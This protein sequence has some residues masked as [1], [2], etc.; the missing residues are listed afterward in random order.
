MVRKKKNNA[1]VVALC[2]I[3]FMVFAFAYV[4]F[5][6]G[7]LLGA[8]HSFLSQGRT[9]GYNCLISSIVVTG[10]ALLMEYAVE[11]LLDYRGYV[12]ACNY[13]PSAFFLGFITRFDGQYLLGD[14][15]VPV[16]WM[17]V[18]CALAMIVCKIVQTG[19]MVEKRENLIPVASNSF[20]LLLVM[21][22]VPIIGNTDENWH[23]GLKMERLLNSGLVDD[24][25]NVGRY[26][27]ESDRTIDLLRVRALLA[28]D[29]DTLSI[30]TD[31]ADRLFS[32][33]IADRMAL[34]SELR[35]IEQSD[36]VNLANTLTLVSY[37]LEKRLDQF[38]SEFDVYSWQETPMPR[39][40]VQ[41]IVL[42]D[43]LGMEVPDMTYVRSQSSYGDAVDEYSAFSSALRNIEGQPVRIRA[44]S[45]YLDH[46]ESLYWFYRF[47][48]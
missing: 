20:L 6:Q 1:L 18:V 43:S 31:V 15:A 14:S 22:V 21:A 3:L 38:L 8:A 30:G 2:R 27:S 40:F 29:Q 39:Y 46:H 19:I 10:L 26:E 24:A 28:N 42:A 23:R 7:D 37:L 11:R 47:A 12:Y 25:L 9:A 16:I 5:F 33:S 4:Y 34:A 41:A 35:S 48:R 32:F 36:T 45:L 44:N 13:I 17:A